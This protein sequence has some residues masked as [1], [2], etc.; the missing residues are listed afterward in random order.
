MIDDRHDIIIDDSNDS[1]ERDDDD[2]DAPTVTV[3][4]TVVLADKIRAAEREHDD[5]V[6]GVK[7]SDDRERT[8]CGI[9]DDEEINAN[10]L[11]DDVDADDEDKTDIGRVG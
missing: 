4:E 11:L 8:S 10:E 2:D 3:G 9:L 6:G 7:R 1:E 5:V